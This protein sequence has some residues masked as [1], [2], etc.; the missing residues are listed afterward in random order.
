LKTELLKEAHVYVSDVLNCSRDEEKTR[1]PSAD[2]LTVYIVCFSRPP[3]A[4]NH[5]S[6]ATEAMGNEAMKRC[7]EALNASSLKFFCQH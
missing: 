3:A 2:S 4:A 6:W 5:Q 7:E 1:Q